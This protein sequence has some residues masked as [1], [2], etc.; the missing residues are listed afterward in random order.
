MPAID[1]KAR[2]RAA[3]AISKRLQKE[4]DESRWA[5]DLRSS[6]KDK[7]VVIPVE[8][9]DL[10]SEARFHFMKKTMQRAQADSAKAIIFDMNTPGGFAWET[11]ELMMTEL[12][13]ITV[14][15]ITFVNPNAISAGSLIALGTDHIYMAPASVIGAAAVVTGGGQDLQETMAKKFN[16]MMLSVVRNVAKNKGHNPDIAEAFVLPEKEVIVDG[17][18]ISKS[19]D[20]LTLNALEATEEFG[21]KPLLAKGIATTLE[22]II[23][24]EGLEGEIQRVS[25][26]GMEAVAEWIDYLAPFL[27]LLGLA[28]I[29]VEMN[30]PG[31]GVAGLVSILA[32]TLYFFGNNLAGNLA[33]YGHIVIFIIGI[34]LLVAEVYLMPGTFLPGIIG[35]ALI[36]GSLIFA[37]VNMMELELFLDKSPA[38]EGLGAVLAGPTTS[39]AVGV[40]GA[41]LLVM[42]LM[43][44]L[45]ETAVGR[46]LTLEAAVPAGANLDAPVAEGAPEAAPR[47]ARPQIG[48]A[49]SARTALRPAGKALI[50]DRLVD[51]TAG[52]EFIEAG[53]PIRVAAVEGSRVLVERG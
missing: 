31:F 43:R 37:A 8:R 33:G 17:V 44:F 14:P 41:A 34:A 39:V 35:G 28:G 12:Q 3:E 40:I 21:G 16:S 5:I 42:A 49:G 13:S 9:D 27:L 53:A 45:P 47:S 29:Y 18:T 11:S 20:L 48:Q 24:R 52:S 51:V 50:G 36:I 23:E 25:P 46:M 26:Y 30:T 15:T 6:Y 32:F 1:E 7:I 4:H 38:S 2:E 10:V 22:E 19:G